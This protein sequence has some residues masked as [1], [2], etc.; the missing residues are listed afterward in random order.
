MG[1]KFADEYNEAWLRTGYYTPGTLYLADVG[2]DCDGP[3]P[4][5]RLDR[6]LA[7]EFLTDGK[8]TVKHYRP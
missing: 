3:Q 4:P 7:I 2:P 8:D 1:R 5:G 6:D